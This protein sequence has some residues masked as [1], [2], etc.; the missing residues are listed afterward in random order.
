[1]QEY[2]K[3]EMHSPAQYMARLRF[4][5]E[6]AHLA[7][8]NDFHWW[9]VETRPDG[10]VEVTF[11]APTLEWAASTTLAYGPAVEVMEPLELRTMVA[12]WIAAA[13]RKYHQ[14]ENSSIKGA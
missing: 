4:V 6:F 8:R 2:L 1:L 3:N 7:T 14:N 12:A 9:S 5:A 11:P 10:S 13:A